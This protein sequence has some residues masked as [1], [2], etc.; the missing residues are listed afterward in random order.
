MNYL[1]TIDA[2]LIDWSRAQF[3]LNLSLA[4]CAPYIGFGRYHGHYRDYLLS[5]WQTFLARGIQVLATPLWSKLC[6][7]C[8]N[9][10]HP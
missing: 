6:H 8:C 10:H 4:V 1:L 5:H 3:A 7:G 9:W 2:S